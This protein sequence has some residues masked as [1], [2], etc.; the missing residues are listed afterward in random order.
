MGADS[1]RKWLIKWSLAATVGTFVFFMIAPAAG[2]PLKYNQAINILEIVFP[3]FIGYIGSATQ[4]VF[5]RRQGDAALNPAV[6]PFIDLLVKGPV[7]GFTLMI[8]AAITAFGYSNRLTAPP[9]EGM[10]VDTLATVVTL[11]LG[12]LTVSTNAIVGY[13][14]SV[15]TEQPGAA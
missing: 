6:A 12:L 3:V 13:L 9:G 10:G 5:R 14:F 4:F 11:A 1:A 8:A 15:E 7:I 2:Y